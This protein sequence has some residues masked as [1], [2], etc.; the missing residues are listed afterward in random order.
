VSCHANFS[1]YQTDA[2][3]LAA[4][5][6]YNMATTL[7][8]AGKPAESPIFIRL[9]NNGIVTNN[10]SMPQIGGA[11]TDAEIASIRAWVTGLAT[12]QPS[13]TPT[14]TPTGAPDTPL[15]CNASARGTSEKRQ[16]RLSKPQI[17]ASLEAIFG[18]ELLTTAEG[19]AALKLL[20][21]ERAVDPGQNFDN[22]AMDFNALYTANK[23]LV[24][25]A[26]ATPS[27]RTIALSAS[28]NPDMPA[29]CY[30]AL[31]NRFARI[32]YKRDLTTTEKEDLIQAIAANGNARTNLT[33]KMIEILM[34][35]QFTQHLELGMDGGCARSIKSFASS[36]PY[37]FSAP[38]NGGAVI[39]GSTAA[40]TVAG[41]YG[42]EIPANE[43]P[44]ALKRIVIKA[45]S[46]GVIFTSINVNDKAFRPAVYIEG[47]T[48]LDYEVDYAANAVF[49]IGI[50]LPATAANPITV[51]GIELFSRDSLACDGAALDSSDR[52]ALSPFETAARIS[53]R[54]AGIPPDE[55]LL[56]DAANGG[57]RSVSNLST[58]AT[59]LMSTPAA[60]K[61]VRAFAESW[62]NIRAPSNP[63]AAVAQNVLGGAA[64]GYGDE[65]KEELL[66]FVEYIVFEK[67]GTF[68][69]LM[70]DKTA[71]P[72]TDRLAKAYGLGKT[73]GQ[74]K[75]AATD[76]R[77]GVLVR[78]A[79]AVSPI[80]QTRPITRGL[81]LRDRILC[82]KIQSPGIEV[83]NSRNDQIK[84][85]SNEQYSTREIITQ[86]TSPAT[87]QGCHAKINPPG[88][89]LESIGPAGELR[90][91][92]L[93]YNASNAV[94]V[95]HPINTFAEN[96]NV[97][98]SR[99]VPAQ[100]ASQLTA[101][102]A[103]SFKA[104][105]CIA[106]HF[107]A[108]TQLRMPAEQDGCSINDA[109]TAIN[110][111]QPVR[112]ALLKTILSDEILWKAK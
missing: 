44:A 22:E 74:A 48:V 57:T 88:F 59:R 105:Q 6:T 40:V 92:E 13:P 4:K 77:G 112:E 81:Y 32:A 84:A 66:K 12:V 62:L 9:L 102:V 110:A 45:Y 95:R 90:D 65:A 64:T 33:D 83:I 97:D 91:Q 1:G 56:N 78:A 41:W 42:F 5:G 54:A 47:E 16:K 99:I 53:Y 34:F 98:E 94:I 111:N 10:A 30:S 109:T 7:V 87:C 55:G 61:H 76:P 2:Q 103:S 39:H 67:N 14:A 51:R 58:H 70:T 21:D 26:L 79:T 68:S 20:P 38:P 71:F 27:I 75:F 37:S 43:I 82:S 35:P 96:I 11:L 93:V 101:A 46:P 107:I 17:I 86:V 24:E 23:S 29:T 100:N 8:V 80:N 85:L 104:K 18:S 31:V 60:R 49:K 50:Y 69:D 108:N 25:K 106:T 36:S 3:W 73:T 15:A 28:C 19:V 63:S 52:Y 89:A 72:W